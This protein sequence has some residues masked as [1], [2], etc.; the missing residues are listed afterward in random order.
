VGVADSGDDS[1]FEALSVLKAAVV[2]DLSTRG[3][4]LA[5]MRDVAMGASLPLIALAQRLYQDVSRY[6]ELVQQIAPVNS[7]F[8]PIAFRASLN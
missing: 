1:T 5:S 4:S 7:A 8:A 2:Q 3:D 6:D